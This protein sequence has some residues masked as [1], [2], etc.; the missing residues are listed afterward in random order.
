MS[1]YFHHANERAVVLWGQYFGLKVLYFKR[2]IWLIKCTLYGAN[3]STIFPTRNHNNDIIH[4]RHITWLSQREYT[5]KYFI[6]CKVRI[7][8]P[9]MRNYHN[10]NYAL[11]TVGL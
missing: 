5:Y 9:Q 4:L 7:R 2:S 11:R 10:V 8:Y 3:K 1:F 6:L